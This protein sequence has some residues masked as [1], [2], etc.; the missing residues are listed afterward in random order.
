[1]QFIRLEAAHNMLC[2]L[3]SQSDMAR[4]TPATLYTYAA[5]VWLINGL[6][7]RPPSDQTGRAVARMSL[8]LTTDLGHLDQLLFGFDAGDEEDE[9]AVPFCP[10]GMMFL[11]TMVFPPHSNVARLLA[12]TTRIIPHE[13][14]K[15]MFG[16][17][18]KEL[19]LEMNPVVRVQQRPEVPKKWYK[20]PLGNTSY[21]LPRQDGE[22][23]AIPESFLELEGIEVPQRHLE[24]GPDMR[25]Y[26]RPLWEDDD[27]TVAQRAWKIWGQFPSDVFQK[28]GNPM[29]TADR[30]RESSY[31]IL[32]EAQRLDVTID[33]FKNTNLAQYFRTVNVKRVS[34]YDWNTVFDNLFPT[35]GYTLPEKCQ[36]YPKLRYYLDWAELIDT[37]PENDVFDV[38][39]TI[40]EEFDKLIWVPAAKR[41]WLWTYKPERGVENHTAPKKCNHEQRSAQV[42]GPQQHAPLIVWNPK[43]KVNIQWIP[44]EIMEMREEE[45]ELSEEDRSD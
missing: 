28:I 11:R 21:R 36:H 41:D 15:H 1:M 9:E 33:A 26:H 29:G 30:A 13:L 17:T 39:I 10:G 18:M 35:P 8:P 7:N 6:H 38:R 23:P 40:R 34:M 2:H 44:P 32:D 37:V 16:K 24:Y 31:C 5:L 12:D 42:W 27:H 4:S 43:F 25:D 22:E 14:F 3:N 20:V 45:E 19:Q